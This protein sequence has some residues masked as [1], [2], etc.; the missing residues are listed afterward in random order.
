MSKHPLFRTFVAA[1]V[2][3]LGQSAQAQDAYPNL[4]P[5]TLDT[6][7]TSHIANLSLG[8]VAEG[9]AKSGRGQQS[10]ATSKRFPGV[11]VTLAPTTYNASPSV[12]QKVQ[13][14]YLAWARSQNAQ[15][16]D[17][18]Q[19]VFVQHPPLQIWRN[20]VQGDG[21]RTGDVAD[22]LAAY[23]ILN[24][25]IATQTTESTRA[26]ALAV[27]HQVR[28]NLFANP[29]FA[30][31]SAAQRQELAEVWMLNFVVQHAGYSTAHKRG[32]QELLRKL[33][34]AALARFQREMSVDL[35]RFTLTDQGFVARG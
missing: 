21:L 6:Y 32:D 25:L 22:A 7:M 16:A 35:R 1:L 28:S 10:G 18:M 17:Q 23:W 8:S 2:L 3:L 14:E 29:N 4:A 9:N 24:Y 12:S 11:P 26:Q 13:A 15:E 19:K 33:A 27:R 5:S 31:L 20:I 34:A 30:R